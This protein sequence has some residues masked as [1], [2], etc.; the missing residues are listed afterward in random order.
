VPAPTHGEVLATCHVASTSGSAFRLGPAFGTV[1]W[2]ATGV[3][4]FVATLPFQKW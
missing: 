4:R 3:S 2:I 1:L